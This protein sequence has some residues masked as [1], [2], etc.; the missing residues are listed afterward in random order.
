[1]NQNWPRMGSMNSLD[2]LARSTL[3]L[4]V[5]EAKTCREAREQS[6]KEM[7]VLNEKLAAQLEKV[8]LFIYNFELLK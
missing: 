2:R 4:N 1:M 3:S 5:P 6:R 8:F 7:H